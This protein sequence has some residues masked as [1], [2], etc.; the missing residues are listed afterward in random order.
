MVLLFLS[1]KEGHVLAWLLRYEI[2]GS[3]VHI[4]SELHVHEHTLFCLKAF[5]IFENCHLAFT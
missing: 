2:R 3:P 5:F 4:A 1:G